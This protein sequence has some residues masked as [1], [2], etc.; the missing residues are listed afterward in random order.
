MNNL[1]IKYLFFDECDIF[2]TITKSK[3]AV[4]ANIHVNIWLI[5]G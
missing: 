3:M 2:A 1:S 5:V 4:F